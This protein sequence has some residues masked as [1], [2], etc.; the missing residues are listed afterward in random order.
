MYE[1]FD[2]K[3]IKEVIVLSNLNNVGNDSFSGY[4]NTWR[5]E[6]QKEKEYP[7]KSKEEIEAEVNEEKKEK[8]NNLIK[9]SIKYYQ[10]DS[11]KKK[12]LEK[13]F[14]Q[15]KLKINFNSQPR[16][17]RDGKFYTIS[18][19]VFTLYDERFF[20]KIIEIKFEDNNEITSAI[21]LD[22]KDLV[23][24]ARDQLIIYRFQNEKYCLFQKIDENRA[25]YESQMAYSG[26]MA[27]PKT[28]GSLF[29]KEI[30]GNRFIC[31]SNYGF[32]IYALNDKNEYTIVLLETYYQS[33]RTIYELDKDNF[34]FCTQIDCGASLG[35]PAHNILMIDKINLK[36]IT[37]T[38]KE[39]R[40]KKLGGRNY[41]DEYDYY[42]RRNE[43]QAKQITGE[44]NKRIIGS[45]KYTCNTQKFLE[46][47]SYGGHH[48][49]KGSTILKNKFFITGI[50]GNI[51]IFDISTGKQLKRY[52]VLAEGEN[53]LFLCGCN[54]KKW[55]NNND[56]QFIL[57]IKGN[58]ILFEL[59]NN[60]EL[61]IINQAY[62]KDITSLKHL[63][64]KNNQ[65]Y[66]DNREDDSYH[67]SYSY[68]FF[69][70]NKD[71]NKNVIVSIF[72]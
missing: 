59:T 31:V 33:I 65:F 3:I 27:Y 28:Y 10:I 37:N 57:N 43:K 38:E 36:E 49:F 64:E 46:Y 29:I 39:N 5:M 18:K 61:Q 48:Y 44:D 52:E 24:F 25:G 14:K 2:E 6:W 34:I 8:M 72:Y 54:I 68:S 22:N 15:M 55:Y 32:K 53:N 40:L 4:F 62:F 7:N 21:Q 50:D 71:D 20:K 35:G 69:G 9:E 11:D 17:L 47:S 45:L 56:N 41:Y 23:F 13:V 58:I 12:E 63:N 66:D 16:I 42:G 67:C 60:N 19:G 1:D 26:C 70:D 51:L 30:S